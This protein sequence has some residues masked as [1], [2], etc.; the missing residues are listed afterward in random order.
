MSKSATV[1]IV[2][3]SF[4]MRPKPFGFITTRSPT[5]FAETMH[6]ATD[7]INQPFLKVG[8]SMTGPYSIIPAAND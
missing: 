7:V 3:N 2:T 1:S 5:L 6:S 8:H 4:T